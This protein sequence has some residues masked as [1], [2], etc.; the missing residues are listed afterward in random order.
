MHY[1]LCG[2]K[3]ASELPLPELLPWSGD[4]RPADV[5]IVL[6]SVGPSL[7]EAIHVGP[8]FQASRDGSCR[9]EIADVAAYRIEGGRRITIA[10]RLP[11]GE[12]AIRV[13]LLGSVFGLLCHQRGLIPL[14][15]GCVEID[16]KAVAFAGNSG[17]GKS[18]LAAAF[19]RLG[20]P[21]LADDVTVV[22]VNGAARPVVLPSFPGMRLWRDTMDALDIS[23]GGLDRVR[24]EI[25]K[26]LIPI[27]Q[28]PVRSP[29]PLSMVFHLRIAKD[30]RQVG[31]QLLAGSS[32]LSA[33]L[34]SVYRRMSAFRMGRRE[35]LLARL[36]RVLAAPSV[37][38]TR[39]MDMDQLDATVD[40]M[41]RRVRTE[42]ELVSG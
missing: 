21:I 25:D 20:F 34:D 38:L 8:F 17:A 5:D 15:A 41:V 35:A 23:S 36:M 16:G 22:D 18:T 31:D 39:I 26:Y 12:P 19:H 4:D 28:N 11:V 42:M 40:Q 10:P 37:E 3:F 32:A 33:L 1:E 13:F 9:Y 6:G 24:P 7:D 14:H 30:H 29:L 2:L 27:E